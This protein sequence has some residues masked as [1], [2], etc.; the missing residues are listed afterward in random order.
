MTGWRIAMAMGNAEFLAQALLVQMS[1]SG[2]PVLY[3]ALPTVSD[4]RTGAYAPGGIETGLLCMGCA[5]MARFYGVPSAS[6]VGLTNAKVNDA[7]AGYESSNSLNVALL[8]G[9]N[10][11]LHACGWLAGGLVSSFEKFV[12]DADQLGIL[13]HF[14][15]GVDLDTNAQALDAISGS[16]P[17]R[18]LMVV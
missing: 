6:L 2:T 17:C 9:V 14:A 7:Q 13:H 10:F 15:R 12:M 8:S 18:S 4:M 5:Q 1:R 11:M 3:D 16:A